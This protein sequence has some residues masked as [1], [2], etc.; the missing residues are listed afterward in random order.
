MDACSKP[1][2]LREQARERLLRQGVDGALVLTR[3]ETQQ[4]LED[5]QIH[6]IELENQNQNLNE[7]QAQLEV[8]LSESSALYDFSPVG[9]VSLDDAGII[10]KLNLSAARLLGG[11][12]VHMV[13]SILALHVIETDRPVFH[14]LLDKAH[15]AGEVQSA[16]LALQSGELAIQHVNMQV[17]PYRPQQGWQ[18]V[19]VDIN[20]RIRHQRELWATEER[21][22]LALEASG[23]GV[24]D[25]NL[26]SATIVY[27]RRYAEL[28]GFAEH[29]IAGAADHWR[30][31]LHP[32]DRAHALGE[33][34][35]YLDGRREAFSSEERHRC[36]DGSWKWVLNRGAIVSRAPD[37]QALRMVGTVADISGRKSI[38]H[39]L[40]EVTRFNQSVFDSLD[41]QIMV[42]DHDGVTLQTNAAWRRYAMHGA[43]AA[44]DSWQGRK[45]LDILAC[46]VENQP[47]TM[48]AA[49]AGL[50]SVLSGAAPCFKLE[51]PF[52][53]P[54]DKAWFSMKITAMRDAD[55]R[56]VVSHENVS[57]IKAA[58]QASLQLAN[59]DALTGALSRRHFLNLAEQE[60]GR[61][62]RYG[63]PLVLLMLDL[64]HF[65]LIND[66][67]GHATGDIVLM[68]FVQTVKSVLRDSDLIGR[69]GGEEFAVLL[70][71]TSM[72][73]GQ[74]LGQRIIESVCSTPIEAE[75]HHIT[76]TVSAGA[77]CLSGQTSLTDLL[78]HA[79]AALY[80]AKGR[81]R[82]RI[83][84]DGVPG[85]SINSAKPDEPNRA[86]V[87]QAP[88]F[89]APGR[90]SS[91]FGSPCGWPESGRQRPIP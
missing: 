25:W 72:K 46:M 70:P 2:D 66:S 45:Y 7:I 43:T 71:N 63:L 86:P 16:E 15:S 80:Q 4:L 81:G 87:L 13:G 31:S 79:D 83:E 22:K 19:L 23:D 32:D 75:G 91:G 21:W 29:E 18:V 64:D 42:L 61:S 82:N 58:E 68:G 8:A 3:E 49:A 5:L 20:D 52:F 85:E 57:D 65:K 84:V 78:R 6:Q 11:E 90:S 62:E 89:P 44:I 67:F 1:P 36:K 35:A 40:L 69:L 74:A 41:T 30:E 88:L 26:Q 24:W 34:K 38:E 12:R 60:R 9:S 55:K 17:S 28:H 33:L 39:A 54:A 48:Q 50:A 47:R 14:A 27:S 59:T 56:I 10:R 73:G 77:A 37:G 76:Y 53:V 51:A